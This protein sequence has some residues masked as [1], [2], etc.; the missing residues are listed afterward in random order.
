[1]RWVGR[2]HLA[3]NQPV[4][5]HADSGQMLLHRRLFEILPQCLDVGGD[6]QRL[7]I[8][9]LAKLVVLT[10]GEEP[11]DRMQLLRVFLLRMVA[12][13]NSRN[14]FA[15]PS[16]ASAMIAGTTMDAARAREILDG[17]AGSMTLSWWSGF[18]SLSDMA[19]V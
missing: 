5:Q 1:M 7:D 11:A 16:P 8:G 3:G 2:D 12:A 14:R 19:L 17:L 15:A 13:K 9:E 6:M 4:E 18:D 10:P